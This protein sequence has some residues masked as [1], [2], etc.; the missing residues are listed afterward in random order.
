MTNKSLPIQFVRDNNDCPW[1]FCQH[2]IVV[3]HEI[4]QLFSLAN[5]IGRKLR[6]TFCTDSGQYTNPVQ[7][8]HVLKHSLVR[9][10]LLENYRDKGD[11]CPGFFMSTGTTT[12]VAPVESAPMQAI[13]NSEDNLLTEKKRRIFWH[14]YEWSLIPVLTR[15]YISAT[16]LPLCQTP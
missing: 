16:P 12:P 2:L 15:F 1:Q 7:A 10:R 3:C 5:L 14:T 9:Y 6:R 8:K 4:G 11:L 13:F